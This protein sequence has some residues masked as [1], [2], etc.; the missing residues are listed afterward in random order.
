MV[1]DK[2]DITPAVLGLFTTEGHIIMRFEQYLRYSY[3]LWRMTKE[4][5]ST[6]YA[7]CI[8]EFIELDDTLLDVGYSLQSKRE[9]MATGSM[10]AA[11]SHLMSNMIQEELSGIC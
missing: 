1:D 7:A 10:A 3:R 9:A 5:N 11:C 2:L 8:L 6:E 4:F